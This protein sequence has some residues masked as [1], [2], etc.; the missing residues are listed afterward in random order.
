MGRPI[1]A[2]IAE[3]RYREPLYRWNRY[4]RCLAALLRRTFH[5]AP[6]TAA[7]PPSDTQ[8]HRPVLSGLR[9]SKLARLCQIAL[10]AIYLTT[11]RR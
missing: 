9:C 5:V 7:L 10:H 2:C 1:G 4:A 3:N 11:Q 8:P 6:Q